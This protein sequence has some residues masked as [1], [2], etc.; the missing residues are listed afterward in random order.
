MSGLSDLNSVAIDVHVFDDSGCNERPCR[1]E[2]IAFSGEFASDLFARLADE[3]D[4]VGHHGG[5][6][7]LVWKV[8]GTIVRDPLP[9]AV[10]SRGIRT[11]DDEF[12]HYFDNSRKIVIR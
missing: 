12:V 2:R 4:C 5:K 11:Y 6:S 8:S 10:L 3:S 7:S 9:Y 1:R